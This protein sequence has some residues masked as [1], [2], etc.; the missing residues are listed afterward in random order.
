MRLHCREVL[1]GTHAPTTTAAHGRLLALNPCLGDLSSCI[2]SRG[3]FGQDPGCAGLSCPW[4]PYVPLM[5]ATP[6]VRLCLLPEQTGAGKTFTMGGDVHNYAHRGII[7]RALHHV[8]REVDMRL[9]KMYKI[10]VGVHGRGRGGFHLLS[11]RHAT[12]EQVGVVPRGTGVAAGGESPLMAPACPAR[13]AL[14]WNAVLRHAVALPIPGTF[15]RSLLPASP[16]CPML[17]A[18]PGFLPGDLQ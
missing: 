15:R 8:F 2:Q 3:A 11:T 16:A 9:D 14:R 10:Q 6:L 7:P 13:S 1:A 12:G 4:V 17:C 18:D 5:G